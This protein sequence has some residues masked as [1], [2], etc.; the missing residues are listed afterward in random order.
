MS[1]FRVS[2]VT[3]PIQ[4][5]NII[6]T[7]KQILLLLILIFK[8]FVL[9]L[10]IFKRVITTSSVSFRPHDSSNT[11]HLIILPGPR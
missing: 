7:V 10:F 8:H 5:K 9:V 2:L 11:R 1:T 6:Y 4:K 3:S